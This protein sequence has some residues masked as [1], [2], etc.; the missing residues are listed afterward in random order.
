ME[1]NADGRGVET[2]AARGSSDVYYHS[3]FAGRHESLRPVRPQ[4]LIESYN[5]FDNVAILVSD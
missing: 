5:Q 1:K 3:F 4:A 2:Q